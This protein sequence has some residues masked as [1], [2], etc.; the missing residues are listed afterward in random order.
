MPASGMADELAGVLPQSYPAG[1][2]PQLLLKR[3]QHGLQRQVDSPAGVQLHP[4]NLAW[5]VP[6]ALHAALV[7]LNG[8]A[9]LLDRGVTWAPPSGTVYDVMKA[10]RHSSNATGLQL[11]SL[12]ETF[13]IG[14][15][16]NSTVRSCASTCLMLEG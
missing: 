16:S 2:A 11:H 15:R 4:H 7:V 6:L 1:G 13:L 14:S 5:Q 3:G 10:Q 9:V 8:G 12:D